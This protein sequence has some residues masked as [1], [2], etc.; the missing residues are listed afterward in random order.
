VQNANKVRQ[1]EKVDA[2]VGWCQ[3]TYVPQSDS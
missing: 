1:Q 3:C 2:W